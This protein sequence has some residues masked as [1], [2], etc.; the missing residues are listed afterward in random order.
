MCSSMQNV[1][2]IFS[3]SL[4]A[5]QTSFNFGKNLPNQAAH[6]TNPLNTCKFVKKW[7]RSQISDKTVRQHE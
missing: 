5:K 1:G 7:K 6:L 4:L 3:L 2:N